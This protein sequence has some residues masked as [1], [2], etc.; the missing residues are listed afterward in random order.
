MTAAEIR[1]LQVFPQKY[2]IYCEAYFFYQGKSIGCFSL[3]ADRFVQPL[4]TS[5][6]N[7]LCNTAI[8]LFKYEV[9]SIHD[10]S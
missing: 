2:N 1:N 6:Y 3:T 10:S 8:N 7:A 4:H 5:E 9:I